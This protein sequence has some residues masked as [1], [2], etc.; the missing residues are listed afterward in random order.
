M[1]PMRPPALVATLAAVLVF[2]AALPAQEGLAA[3]VVH[4]GDGSSLPLRPWTLSYEYGTW[5]RGS[6]PALA[7]SRSAPTTA[8]WAGKKSYPLAGMTLEISTQMAER[9]REVEGEIRRVQVPVVKG[10]VLVGPDGKRN[11]VKLEPPHRELLAPGLDKSANVLP[12]SLD[13]KGE[14]LTGIKREFC[15][16]SLSAL[17]E[18]QVEA[19]QEVVRLEFPK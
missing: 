6:S 8:L 7:E 12:R 3:V 11:E 18:C 14:T 9:E 15:L 16:A 10:F 5:P 13:L 4:L 2:P 19:G 17:V 1:R